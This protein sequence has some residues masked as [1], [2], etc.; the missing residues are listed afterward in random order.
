MNKIMMKKQVKVLALIPCFILAIELPIFGQVSVSGTVR[1]PTL[2]ESNGMT[3]CPNGFMITGLAGGF[4]HSSIV[5]EPHVIR[6]DRLINASGLGVTLTE[7]Y[8]SRQTLVDDNDMTQCPSNYV[9]VGLSGGFGHSSMYN[10]PHKFSCRALTSN[11]QIANPFRMSTKVDSNEIT[12]CPT[13]FVVI[14]LSGGYGHSS[15]KNEPHDL[16]CGEILSK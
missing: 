15:E 7:N 13:G 6:C 3:F 14:G 10:T 5:N 2:V 11:F 16:L 9:M 1:L 4:G 8:D 12:V